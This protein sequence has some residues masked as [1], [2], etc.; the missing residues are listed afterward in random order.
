MSTY[1][2]YEIKQIYIVYI[3]HYAIWDPKETD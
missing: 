2:L 1:K 3:K